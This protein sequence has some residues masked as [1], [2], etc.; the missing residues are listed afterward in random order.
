MSGKPV[1][2]TGKDPQVWALVL[3]WRGAELTRECLKSLAGVG[4]PGL[5]VLL[6][7]NGSDHNDG[8][9]LKQEFPSIELLRLDANLG[10][11]GGCNAGMMYCMER[12]AEFIWLLNN[13]TKV[14]EEALSLLMKQAIEHPQAAAF[15][16]L[17]VDDLLSAKSDG[18]GAKIRSDG[19]APRSDEPSRSSAGLNGNESERES[20]SQSAAVA[21]K[22]Q[23][24]LFGKNTRSGRYHGAQDAR[25][26][27]AG[28]GRGEIDF[29]RAK[30][31]LRSDFSGRVVDC[32]WLSGSNLLLR[33]SALQMAGLFDESYFL[34][35]EDTELCHRLRLG[36]WS[37]LL[38]P[39]AIIEHTGNA[40][41]DG[42]RRFWRDYYYTRNRLLFFTTYLKGAKSIP[43]CAFIFAHL[44]RHAIVLPFR[45]ERGR[46][47]LKAEMLGARD[48]ICRSFGKAQCLDW[49]D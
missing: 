16:A 49:C 37:C 14:T 18:N 15:G 24:A 31:F 5:T 12:G 3:H 26:K 1:S 40:S 35:F 36:G 44:L 48:F 17:M 21:D 25:P 13:D 32:Q 22:A 39:D 33:S 27:T 8:A 43:A 47:Q 20:E 41:T 19:E 45:G 4:Y 28:N 46:C 11:A 10:F 7:D 30:T 2:E 42:K 34:Y 9:K 29:V 6:V 23:H 38:V